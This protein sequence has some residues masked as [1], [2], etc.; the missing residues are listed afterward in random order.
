MIAQSKSHKRASGQ[1]ADEEFE[2]RKQ[3]W[4]VKDHS[5]TVI[6]VGSYLPAL[7]LICIHYTLFTTTTLN[8]SFQYHRNLS[9][10]MQKTSQYKKQCKG[11]LSH[12]SITAKI[13]VFVF[14]FADPEKPYHTRTNCVDILYRNEVVPIWMFGVS[15]PLGV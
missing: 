2:R 1:D 13:T 4:Q 7:C 8:K 10:S 12:A 14:E 3:Q 9:K 11:D 5:Y 6:S 15:L